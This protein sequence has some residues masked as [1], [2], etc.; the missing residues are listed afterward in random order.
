MTSAT[1][2]KKS[3]IDLA[4]R[5]QFDLATSISHE[6]EVADYFNEY[7][8]TN[9]PNQAIL[10]RMSSNL[11]AKLKNSNGMYENM[12]FEVPTSNNTKIIVADCLGGKSVG[13]EF[14]PS[15]GM[16]FPP[17]T[18]NAFKALQEGG[19]SIMG[20]AMASPATGKPVLMTNS[21]I[22]DND[23][24]QLTAIYSSALDLN[25]LAQNI[26][27]ANSYD[28]IKTFLID[29]TGLVVSSEDSS[30]Y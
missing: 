10:N 1:S 7:K 21:P 13:I 17:F 19:K 22:I 5:N 30:K 6:N 23:T 14:P 15:A 26:V 16:E 9:Q 4:F 29:S 18:E 25:T 8:K 11:E 12:F 24:K 3:Y 28:N 2:N 27:K 20:T